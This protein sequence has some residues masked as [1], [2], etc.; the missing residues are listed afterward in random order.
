MQPPHLPRVHEGQPKEKNTH[1]T[2][3]K[4]DIN[5]KKCPKYH[6]RVLD[7]RIKIQMSKDKG[8]RL[9]QNQVATLY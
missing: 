4:P 9:H 5:M 7:P 6:I 1:P 2:K 8:I 3:A